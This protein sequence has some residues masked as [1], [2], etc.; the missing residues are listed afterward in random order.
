[1]FRRLSLK[2]LIPFLQPI[3]ITKLE[4]L[5]TISTLIGTKKTY[6]QLCESIE[7]SGHILWTMT[8]YN[9][10]FENGRQSSTTLEAGQL[11]RIKSA[12]FQIGFPNSPSVPI[13]SI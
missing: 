9:N 1:M 12:I 7:L 5:R 13:T 8:S 2:I 6:S 4:T 11:W 10:H 3:E